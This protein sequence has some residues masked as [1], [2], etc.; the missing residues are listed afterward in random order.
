MLEQAFDESRRVLRTNGHLLLFDAVLNREL[1]AGRLLWRLDRGSYP[2][3][4]VELREKFAS[5]FKI[6]H[7]E[8]FVIYHEYV[9][10]IGIRPQ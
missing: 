10:G 4:E 9:L 5:K 2:R 6:I 3:T 1:C 8:K 7:W